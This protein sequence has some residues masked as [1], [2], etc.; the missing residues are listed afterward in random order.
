MRA[1]M[2]KIFGSRIRAKILGWF[3]THTD[4][5][6]FVR[7]IASILKEDPTNVSREM[8]NLEKLGILRSGRN[9]N[10]KLFQASADCPFFKEL[11]WLVLKTTGVAGQIRAAIEKFPGIDYAFIYGSYAKGDERHNS[12]VDILIIGD[13]NLDRLDS[14]LG[15]LEKTLGREISYVLYSME[16]FKSKKKAKDRFLMGVLSGKKIMVVGAENG[17]KRKNLIEKE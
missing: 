3:F 5:S 10:L 15:K 12:D 14:H 13:V 11:K 2:E 16:E 17:L 6:F 4:E 7:Q 9:G 8:A 1:A